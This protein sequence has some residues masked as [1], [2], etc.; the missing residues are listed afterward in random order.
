MPT[1]D[2]E[3]D[4]AR[5]L[6]SAAWTGL[7]LTPRDPQPSPDAVGAVTG[8]GLGLESPRLRASVYVFESWGAGQEVGARL[9]ALLDGDPYRAMS[10]VNGALLLVAICEEPGPEGD[11][12]LHRLISAFHG[13]E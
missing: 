7:D 5:A 9:E 4:R 12:A 2:E 8:F 13:M 3:L 10:L 1:V 11:A 6:T